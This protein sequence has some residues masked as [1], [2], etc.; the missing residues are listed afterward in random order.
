MFITLKSLLHTLLLPPGGPL[1]IAAAG[2]WLL[3]SRSAG[4]AR[5]GWLLLGAGLASLWLLATPLVADALARA[6]EREPA[7]DLTRASQA[8]AI[9]ILGGGEERVA[10]PEYGGEP[11]PGSVLL[12]RVTY[13]AFLAHHTALPVLVSG[14]AEEALA[15]RASLA[16]GFGIQVRWVEDRSRDTFQNAQFSA[17]LLKAA[18][19]SRILLVTDSA[20]EWRASHEF[21]SAGLTVLPAPVG[22]W[23]PRETGLL[24]YLP[25]PA[26]LA[27]SSAAL[28]ELL[29]DVVRRALAALRLRTQEA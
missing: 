24:R 22:V 12:E 5:A 15:M 28:Y 11:A 26:A 19:V 8:Q 16:R 4:A 27:R 3:R 21:A 23:A 14:T 6:A 1:L 13:A 2:A 29:G 25:A 7:L 18:G 17:R 10:A 9:V 20:H